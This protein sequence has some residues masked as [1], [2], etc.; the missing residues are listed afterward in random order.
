M[1]NISHHTVKLEDAF[2]I[3]IKGK[4]EYIKEKR[5]GV[6]CI[7]DNIKNAVGFPLTAA[8]DFINKSNPRLKPLLEIKKVLQ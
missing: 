1:P 4:E 7:E 3:K 8:K 5:P 6:Y 2:F